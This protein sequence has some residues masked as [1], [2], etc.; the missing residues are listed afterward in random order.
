MYRDC[1]V[2]FGS[3]LSSSAAIEVSTIV[4]LA[5]VAGENIKPIEIAVC[6]QRVEHNFIGV[7][8]GIMDQYASACGKKG[9]AML[10]DCSTLD[11]EYIPIELGA[12]CFVII[13]SKKPHNLVESK[14]NQRREEV[15]YALYELQK[16]FRIN[17]LAELMPDELESSRNILPEVI[18]RRAK[19]VVE[20][21]GRVLTAKKAMRN[22]DMKTLGAILNESHF[23]LRDNY[24]VTG[25]E[26][27]VLTEAAR[28]SKYCLGSRMTGGG[29][30]G[31]TIALVES[32]HV[33]QFTQAVK[34]EYFKRTGYSSE[35]CPVRIC[36]GITV[37]E[38]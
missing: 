20:E 10:L 19:H 36:E 18:Y 24:E 3:G 4:A 9:M 1:T 31:S 8:C 6:A 22:G 5:A 16:H 37:T 11:C 33:E 13:D 29:F 35:S 2:P 12:Y 28:N 7:N 14:Y 21:C 38:I 34:E 25:Y 30:G 23:S 17:N 26:L 32:A 15:E 27:D